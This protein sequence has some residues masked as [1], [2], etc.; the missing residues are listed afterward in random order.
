MTYFKRLR[1]IMV[2]L[3]PISDPIYSPFK[4]YPP[5]SFMPL[6]PILL[7]SDDNMGGYLSDSLL[8]FPIS[9]ISAFYCSYLRIIYFRVM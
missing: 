4:I 1:N 7:T 8:L 6:Y 2:W 5:Q 9:S 3:S